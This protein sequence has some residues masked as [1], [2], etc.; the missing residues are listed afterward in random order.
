M[1]VL[2]RTFQRFAN[3]MSQYVQQEINESLGTSL[4]FSLVSLRPTHLRVD[5][6]AK[7]N[8]DGSSVGSVRSPTQIY[9]VPTNEV[10]NRFASTPHDFRDDLTELPAGT[11]VY[12]VYATNQTIR[13]SIFPWVTQRYARERRASAVKVGSLKTTSPF[14]TSQF[15]DSGIF[16]KHQ[17]YE[18][19]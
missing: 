17:R 4:I 15:G 14:T 12:D 9:F 5:D 1:A 3:E 19:R 13:T 16:F 18:D 11:T 10:R 6:M 7:V 2:R 8:Q